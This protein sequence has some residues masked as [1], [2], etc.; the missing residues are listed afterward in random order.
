M[1]KGKAGLGIALTAL[2]LAIMIAVGCVVNTYSEQIS[3]WWSGTFTEPMTRAEY[4][5]DETLEN[6]RAVSIE[7]ASEGV[8]LLKN[9]NGA[10]PLQADERSVSLVGYGSHNPVYCGAGSVSWNTT[11]DRSDF[12]DAFTYYD[13]SINEGLR[14]YYTKNFG[15]RDTKEGQSEMTGG[16]FTIYDRS[17]SEYESLLQAGGKAG[18]VA[19]VT[20]SRMGGENN[21]LP[22]DMGDETLLGGSDLVD[23]VKSFGDVGKSYLE[24]QD[25]ELD[26]LKAVRANY[27]KVIVLLNTCNAMECGPLEEYADAILWIGQPGGRGTYSVVSILVGETNPSGRMVD[28]YAHEHETAPTFYTSLAA[29]YQNFDEFGSLTPTINGITYT[30]DNKVDGAVN[31]YYENIYVGYKWYET[32]DAEGY[33]E[34]VSVVLYLLRGL[35]HICR[36]CLSA[37]YGALL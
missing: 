14:E 24:L 7:Q 5:A 25:V 28:T 2:L 31:Y 22:M 27:S 23:H 15:D 34:S 30:V 29:T 4:T 21:D 19:V 12:Y 9:D 3:Y 26:M 6:G 36:R 13:F 11:G 18:D 37:G 20:L 32:A 17:V 1:K 16:D 33:R 8:V 35:L 10:L